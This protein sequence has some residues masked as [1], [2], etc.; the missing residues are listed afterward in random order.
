MII[1]NVQIDSIYPYP[2]NPREIEEGQFEKLKKSLTEFGFV[3]PLVVNL[4]EDSSFKDK[5]KVLTVV[6]GNMR[7]RAA[8]SLGLKEVPIFEI[9]ISKHKEA[10]LNIGLNRIVGKWDISKLEKMVYEFKKVNGKKGNYWLYEN[11]SFQELAEG[12]RTMLTGCVVVQIPTERRGV[13]K[14]STKRWTM[15]TNL[16]TCY[17][18][19]PGLLG[20]IRYDEKFKICEDYD[21]GYQLLSNGMGAIIDYRFTHNAK[22][23][24]NK[25]GCIG[26]RTK[27]MAKQTTI[28]FKKKYG[29]MVKT[30]FNKTSGMVEVRWKN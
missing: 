22:H 10:I 29:D 26:W 12:V 19:N 25:G 7:L 16:H 27:E 17:F 24:T 2:E 13:L 11:C 14:K 18:V 20:S 5:E 15:I 23:W 21:F 1:K 30:I 8:K 28:Q 9:N 3:E 6:G 4:R